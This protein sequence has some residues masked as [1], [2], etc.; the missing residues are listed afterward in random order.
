MVSVLLGAVHIS[1]DGHGLPF[2]VHVYLVKCCQS[3]HDSGI[4][5]AIS[6]PLLLLE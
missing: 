5:C 3:G 2:A 4:P 1:C 6:S